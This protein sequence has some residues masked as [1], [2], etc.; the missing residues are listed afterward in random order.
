MPASTASTASTNTILTTDA[1]GN[2]SATASPL[3]IRHRRAVAR[4]GA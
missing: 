2:R 4:N 3:A 1:G